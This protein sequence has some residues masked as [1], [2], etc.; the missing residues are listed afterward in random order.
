MLLREF[1]EG[2]DNLVSGERMLKLFHRMQKQ[3]IGGNPGMENYILNH[4]WRYTEVD[5]DTLPDADS[6]GIIDPFSRII[7]VDPDIVDKYV[8]AVKHGSSLMPIILGPNNAV[9]DGNHRASAYKLL[10][11]DVPAYVPVEQQNEFVE[12]SVDDAVVFHDELNPAFWANGEMKPIIRYKLLQIAMDFVKF[13]GIKQLNLTDV[14]MTGSNA[15][16]NYTKFSDVDLH[17]VVN[18]PDSDVFKELYDSKKGLWNEQH[19][20]KVKGFDVEVYVQDAAE[21][22]I[23]SGMYSVLNN[24]WIKEPKPEKPSINDMSVEHKYHDLHNE[25]EKAVQEGNKAKLES[26]K[27][28]IKKM[29][30][31]GLDKDGEFSVENLAFKMLRNLGDMEALVN[32]IAKLRDQE[33]SIEQA[34]EE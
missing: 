22:H 24:K 19:N 28:K 9:I 29:R 31:S 13:I 14:I 21:K 25:I 7:D 1:V 17:L 30:Q 32:A 27:D 10:R 6:D 2:Q 8:H 34:Q 15:S 12:Q 20:V 4:Q 3:D 16:Y 5:P 33:L 18:I 11:K 23:S 26:L